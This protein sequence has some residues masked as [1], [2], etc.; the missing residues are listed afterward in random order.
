MKLPAEGPPRIAGP[1]TAAFRDWRCLARRGTPKVPARHRKSRSAAVPG[2]AIRAALQ[3]GVSSAEK[4][5]RDSGRRARRD[6]RSLGGVGSLRSRAGFIPKLRTRPGPVAREREARAG[7]G[8]MVGRAFPVVSAYYPR[9]GRRRPSCAHFSNS[10]SASPRT[11]KSDLFP[12]VAVHRH[13]RLCLFD[14][15]SGG[16]ARR[17]VQTGARGRGCCNASNLIAKKEDADR[18]F[19]LGRRYASIEKQPWK[20]FVVSA[21]PRS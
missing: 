1:G 14:G 4:Y 18:L 15:N 3:L 16:D 11:L 5:R 7:P 10:F 19:F 8:R 20:A 6:G 9:A 17:Q 2:P 21:K 13:R 12:S